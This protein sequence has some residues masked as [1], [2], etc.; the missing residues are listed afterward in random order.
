[1]V[2]MPAS[3]HIRIGSWGMHKG[4]IQVLDYKDL[5]DFEERF[6]GVSSEPAGKFQ[7]I[8][9]SGRYLN[10]LNT[11]QKNPKNRFLETS[12]NPKP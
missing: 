12:I 9:H 10:P 1:M 11:K 2:S 3:V 8:T 7:V 6:L 5:D 4:A